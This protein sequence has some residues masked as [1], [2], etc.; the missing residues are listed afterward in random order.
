MPSITVSTTERWR[1]LSGEARREVRRGGVPDTSVTSDPARAIAAAGVGRRR[2][3][4]R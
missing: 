1:T 4:Y 2:K 3:I